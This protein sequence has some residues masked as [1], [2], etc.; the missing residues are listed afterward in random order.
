MRVCVNGSGD[1]TSNNSVCRGQITA[2]RGNYFQHNSGL[3]CRFP[4]EWTFGKLKKCTYFQGSK[5]SLGVLPPGTLIKLQGQH[6]FV[7]IAMK[8]P[9]MQ[10]LLRGFETEDTRH[11]ASRISILDPRSGCPQMATS[12]QVFEEILDNQGAEGDCQNVIPFAIL[13]YHVSP[14]EPLLCVSVTGSSGDGHVFQSKKV[15]DKK[16]PVPVSRL[17]FGLK[18]T[19][20]KRNRAK[21]GGTLPGKQ[22]KGRHSFTGNGN[23]LQQQLE[24]FC[25]QEQ[26]ESSSDSCICPESCESSTSSSSSDS[27]SCSSLSLAEEPL[28]TAEAAEEEK[29]VASVLK[30]HKTLQCLQKGGHLDS[31]VA[32]EQALPSGSSKDVAAA[33]N[34]ARAATFCNKSIGV[35]D[36]GLQVASKLATCKQ[37]SGKVGKGT[38][39]WAYAFSRSKFHSWIHDECIVEHLRKQKANL[40]QVRSFLKE[41]RQKDHPD[42]I[43]KAVKK[44]QQDLS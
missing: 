32:A 22:K 6:Y 30:S 10:V 4:S 7:G 31:D 38:V 16:Q 28:L 40:D 11:T 3:S 29:E 13:T 39:R 17:A 21:Q 43:M 2:I 33:A 19:P 9:Q 37:C 27:E 36:V 25:K 12:Q 42:L 5:C 24:D 34:K 20:K 35:V 18:Q 15:V 14:F 44:L 1:F 41:E 23:D 8:K 26:A